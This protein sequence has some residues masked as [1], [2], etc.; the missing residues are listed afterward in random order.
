MQGRSAGGGDAN[1]PT[2]YIARDKTSVDTDYLEELVKN[3][4]ISES[5]A[6]KKVSFDHPRF[7]KYSLQSFQSTLTKAK[8]KYQFHTQPLTKKP[9]LKVE[10]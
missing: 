10:V 8:V 4:L 7:M 6:P 3:K 5:A 2:E 1:N 9:P